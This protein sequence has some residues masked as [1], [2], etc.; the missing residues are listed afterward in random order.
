MK[1]I[2][3]QITL[4]L[5]LFCFAATVILMMIAVQFNNPKC[6]I[7]GAITFLLMCVFSAINNICYGK[8][9]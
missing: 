4:I 8:E 6:K 5:G 1:K 3:Q 9:D 7:A 2:F